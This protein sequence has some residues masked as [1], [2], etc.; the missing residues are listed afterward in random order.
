M[1]IKTRQE[2]EEGSELRRRGADSTEPLAD[3]HPWGRGSIT[4]SGGDRLSTGKAI[5]VDTQ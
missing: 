4:D 5:Q 2:A 3:V 1:G